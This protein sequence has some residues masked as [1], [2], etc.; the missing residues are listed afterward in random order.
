[1]RGLGE[2]AGAVLAR[3]RAMQ[4]FQN[5]VIAKFDKLKVRQNDFS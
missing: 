1:M 2:P 5:R 4:R 3:E